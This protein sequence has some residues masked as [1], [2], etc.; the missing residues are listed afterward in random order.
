MVSQGLAR[1]VRQPPKTAAT[2]TSRRPCQD[3]EPL[4]TRVIDASAIAAEAAAAR[5]PVRNAWSTKMPTTA[6]SPRAVQVAGD[7][8]PNGNQPGG[9]QAFV[10]LAA[11]QTVPFQR[12][13]PSGESWPI[14]ASGMIR[15]TLGQG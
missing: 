10:A 2:A 11:S 14:D 1:S 7:P 15:A 13:K 5:L 12:Q 9:V 8:T 6:D 4:T 3:R